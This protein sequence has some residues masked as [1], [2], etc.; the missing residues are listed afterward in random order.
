MFKPKEVV[1]ERLF[2]K[3]ELELT[4]SNLTPEEAAQ[5]IEF[6]IN[7]SHSKVISELINFLLRETKSSFWELKTLEIT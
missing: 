3:L 2:F 7:G 5:R 1:S 4:H 6:L